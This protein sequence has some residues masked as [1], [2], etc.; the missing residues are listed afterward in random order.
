L[1][2]AFSLWID[3]ISEL[4]IINPVNDTTIFER[5]IA[6]RLGLDLRGGLQV[7]LEADLPATTTVDAA[8]SGSLETNG[9]TAPTTRRFTARCWPA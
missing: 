9:S 3:F 5:N 1:I 2:V 6:T 7:L 4:K 8:A